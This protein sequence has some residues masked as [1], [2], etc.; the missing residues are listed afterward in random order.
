MLTSSN[1]LSLLVRLAIL[2]IS[3]CVAV[4]LFA[5]LVCD[6]SSFVEEVLVAASFVAALPF[7]FLVDAVSS[8]WCCA[9]FEVVVMLGNIFAIAL[10]AIFLFARKRVSQICLA[11]L[12]SDF[13]LALILG[14]TVVPTD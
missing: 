12:L 1:K 10:A 5:M 13:A 2:A 9:H 4:V 14:C 6:L 7:S 3:Y 8:G 11:L